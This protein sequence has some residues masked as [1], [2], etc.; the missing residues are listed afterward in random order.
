MS[1]FVQSI[2]PKPKDVQFTMMIVTIVAN[3]FFEDHL[4]NNQLIT[5][6][7]FH[8]LLRTVFLTLQGILLIFEIPNHNHFSEHESILHC[9]FISPEVFYLLIKKAKKLELCMIINKTCQ[10]SLDMM[11]ELQNI[12]NQIFIRCN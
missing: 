4:I 11:S 6:A 3:K 12:T 5:T 7:L 10:R 9:R 2:N 1:C 8:R